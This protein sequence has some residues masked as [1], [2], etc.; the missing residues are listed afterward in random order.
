M[1][2]LTSLEILPVNTQRTSF[3]G[4][5]FLGIPHFT[6]RLFQVCCVQQELDVQGQVGKGGDLYN[7][8]VWVGEQANISICLVVINRLD[9]CFFRFSRSIQT[10]AESVCA[11]VSKEA[12]LNKEK[13]KHTSVPN[14]QPTPQTKIS[15]LKSCLLALGGNLGCFNQLKMATH[16]QSNNFYRHSKQYVS[17]NSIPVR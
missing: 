3:A 2:V 7:S 5:D 9:K 11:Q 14:I 16:A 17:I 13:N 6:T 10:T 4:K 15:F 8:G 12:L 1:T